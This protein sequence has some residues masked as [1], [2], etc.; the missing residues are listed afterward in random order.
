MPDSIEIRLATASDARKLA[1]MSRDLVELGLGWSWTQARVLR[2]IKSADSAVLVAQHRQ[3]VIAFAIMRFGE[4]EA[5]LD[6]LAVRP[7][8]RRSGVG[9]R[10]VEWL[11]RSALVAGVSVVYLE[12][13]E[14]NDEARAFYERLGY[15][16]VARLSGYYRGRESA[17]CMGRDLWASAQSTAMFPDVSGDDDSSIAT[18]LLGRP[19]SESRD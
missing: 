18:R 3:R 8:F 16:R 13:R 11:E 15:S 1:V 17:V 19:A 4:E 2:H 12:V 9:R 6:L 14:N 10:L 5:H 7:K